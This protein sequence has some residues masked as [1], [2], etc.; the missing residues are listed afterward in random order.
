MLPRATRKLTPRTATK[1][2]KSL[3]RFS[4]SRTVSLPTM[5]PHAGHFPKLWGGR[6]GDK[7][8]RFPR[9]F[10]PRRAFHALQSE[11]F[12]DKAPNE[13]VQGGSCSSLTPSH[14]LP[15]PFNREGR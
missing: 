13:T 8:A 4:V 9:L 7:T 10:S 14:K 1:P 6:K 12:S 11:K 2:A 15:L 5:S 3:E